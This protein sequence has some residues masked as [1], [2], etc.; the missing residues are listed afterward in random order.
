MTKMM[1]GTLWGK[2][3][4]LFNAAGLASFV[5]DLAEVVVLFF[6]IRTSRRRSGRARP[7]WP[8]TSP[9]RAPAHLQIG[10]HFLKGGHFKEWSK[11]AWNASRRS[12][13]GNTS[14]CGGA[15]VKSSRVNWLYDVCMCAYECNASGRCRHWRENHF[16]ISQISTGWKLFFLFFK[17]IACGKKWVSSFKIRAYGQRFALPF[18]G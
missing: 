18:K 13:R 4:V 8:W 1:L 16:A 6:S 3:I 15:G 14:G 2:E 10:G 9:F 12:L 5:L 11:C 7:R 17:N